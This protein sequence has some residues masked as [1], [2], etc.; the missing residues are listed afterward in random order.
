MIRKRQQRAWKSI[1]QYLATC[2]TRPYN[3]P[4]ALCSSL[5]FRRSTPT[6]RKRRKRQGRSRVRPRGVHQTRLRFWQ[7]YRNTRPSERM[8]QRSGFAGGEERREAD[9]SNFGYESPIFYAGMGEGRP[10]PPV[11]CSYHFLLV[12]VSVRTSVCPRRVGV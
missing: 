8:E 2:Y 12:F 5:C 10:R 3:I 1:V 11:L 6:L 7:D 4:T 9:G